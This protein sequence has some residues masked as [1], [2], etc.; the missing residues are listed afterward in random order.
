MVEVSFFFVITTYIRVL[1]AKSNFY[2]LMVI[3]IIIKEVEIWFYIF[4]LSK[5]ADELR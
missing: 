5:V 2:L 3:Y 1:S 4:S